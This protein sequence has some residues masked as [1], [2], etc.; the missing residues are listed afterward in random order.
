M[1]P[2]DKILCILTDNSGNRVNVNELPFN[3][4]TI[5]AAARRAN[6]LP[7]RNGTRGNS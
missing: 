7:S 4:R 1:A 3:I 5:V 2:S 6:L